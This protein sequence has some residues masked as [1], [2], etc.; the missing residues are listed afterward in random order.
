MKKFIEEFNFYSEPSVSKVISVAVLA[1]LVFSM[2]T[3]FVASGE[4]TAEEE[5]KADITEEKNETDIESGESEGL[6]SFTIQPDEEDCKDTFIKNSSTS[7]NEGEST[8]LLVGNFGGDE[9]RPLI[10]FDLPQDVGKLEHATLKLYSFSYAGQTN[11]TVRGLSSGWDEGTGINTNDMA[12]NWTH[13]TDS[14]W[15]SNE[16]GDYYSTP[17]SYRNCDTN[18]IWYSWDVTDIVDLWITNSR[19]NNGFILQPGQYSSGDDYMYFRSSNYSDPELRPKLTLSYSSEI[20]PPVP[21]QTMNEDDPTKTIS[22]RDREHETIVNVSGPIDHGNA[23]PFNNYGTEIRYQAL[24]HSEQVGADGV[25]RRIS[26]SRSQMDVGNFSNVEIY[27]AHTSIDILTDTFVNNYH[28]KPVQVFSQKEVELNSSN[29]DPWIYFDLNGSFVYDSFFNL[30]VEIRWNGHG[31]SYVYLQSTNTLGP[32]RRLYSWDLESDTGDGDSSHPIARF[33]TEIADEFTRISGPNHATS[34]RPFYGNLNDEYH[35]QAVYTPDQVGAE[36]YIERISFDKRAHATSASFNNLNI[37]LAHTELDEVTTTFDDNYDGHLVEVFNSP[38]V[39]FPATSTALWRHFDLNNNFIYDNEH[40]LLIDIKWSGDSDNNIVVNN[41]EYAAGVTKRVYSGDLTSS[42]GNVDRWLPRLKFETDII[43]NTVVDK[44]TLGTTWPFYPDE[45]EMRLQMLHN[46]TL[47]NE[48]GRIDKISFQAHDNEQRWSVYENFSIRMAH[49]QNQSLDENYDEH[50]IDPWI[51]V[52]NRTSYNISTQGNPEWIEIDIDNTFDYNGE[53]NLVIDVRWRG[54]Y[55]DTVFLAINTTV[56]YDCV[57]AAYD[58]NA[59]VGTYTRS[60]LYNLQATFL[61]ERSYSWMS[62]SSDESLF[63]TETTGNWLDGWDLHITPQPDAYGTGTLTLRL[64]NS[65][66]KVAFNYV[67]VTINGVNDPPTLSGPSSINCDEDV[68]KVINMS[69]YADDIDNTIDELTF[70]TNS[71]YATVDG[72]SITF[73]YPDGVLSE[74]VNTTVEDPGGLSDYTIVQVTVDPVNDPPELSG[75]DEIE[76]VEDVDYVLDMSAYASD[77]DNDLE[78]LT[79]E[80]NSSYAAVDGHNIT[81]NYPNGV[82]SEIVNITTEDPDGL[83]DHRM[84]QVTVEPVNNPPFLSG[85]PDIQCNEGEDYELDM[86]SYVSDIDNDLEE[87][88]FDTDSSYATINGTQIVFHYTGGITEEVVN[89]TVEDPG[90]LSDYAVIQVTVNLSAEYPDVESYEPTGSG[91]SPYENIVVEFSM[92]MDKDTVE[93]A[94][95]LTRDGTEISGTFSWNT[96][97]TKMT[98][99]PTDDLSAGNYTATV[100]TSAKST[101]GTNLPSEHTWTFSVSTEDSDGD[102]MPDA[103]EEDHGL[104]PNDPSDADEDLDGDGVKNLQEYLD[105]TDPT[106]ANDFLI[107]E[108]DDDEDEGFLSSRILLLIATVIIALIL[109]VVIMNKKGGKEDQY[110]QQEPEEVAEPGAQYLEE[111]IEKTPEG[112]PTDTEPLYDEKTPPPEAEGGI[113]EE[114]EN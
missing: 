67:Q 42:F 100:T 18:Y 59:E 25:I 26:F 61:H 39:E 55:G 10:Q 7:M 94:F 51:E 89:I 49:S 90:G 30:I 24:Y 79:F 54:S 95:T 71:S 2:L 103:W 80:T 111:P 16:G 72:S 73:N 110:P 53:D 40:N 38:S 63:T 33:E 36:G 12:A 88:T 77:I 113:E 112:P 98:F 57:I 62:F 17:K 58:Y 44:G 96:A 14:E 81:F 68:E 34:A 75:P 47:L 108:D 70:S 114:P 76:C 5:I 65:Q 23:N 46:H 101:E 60:W 3:G 9:W 45:D 37:S 64:H 56:S 19:E 15:W 93:S 27:L 105:G 78:E 35:F 43:H 102:G 29:N 6:Q 106:N 50:N 1:I 97:E 20:D 82:L 48:K 66:G 69:A 4:G 86:T 31:G 91:V 28:G 22:L 85:V 74:M 109:I 83:S 99:D 92:A 13:R 32:A 41:T 107:D 11:V 87:L 104:D 52:F 84:V 21:D 8:R